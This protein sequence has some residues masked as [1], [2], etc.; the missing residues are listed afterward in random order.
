MACKSGVFSGP[1]E[2]ADGPGSGGHGPSF[3]LNPTLLPQPEQ[4]NWAGDTR[5]VPG[6]ESD[7]GVREGCVLIYVS[8]GLGPV[9]LGPSFLICEIIK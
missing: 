1:L 3:C 5:Q 9:S 4:A 8:P 7:W 6:F 2:D